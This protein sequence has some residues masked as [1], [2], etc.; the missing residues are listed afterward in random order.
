MKKSFTLGFVLFSVAFIFAQPANDNCNTATIVTPNGQCVDG[1]TVGAN[2]SWTQTVGCQ[3]GNNHPDVWYSFVAT[4]TT[5]NINVTAGT[6]TGDIEFVLVA[7]TGP[8]GGLTNA[9]SLCG[10][11]PLTGTINGIQIGTTYYYTI[12]SSTSS[13]GTF[14]TC[15]TNTTPPP[16]PGQDCGTS[17]TLCNVNSFSQ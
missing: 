16:L 9:G 14:T 2:D 8:C 5:V 11:S 7:S 17:A 3:S 15:V 10:A 1:T 6:L 4:G 13:Q 12:S